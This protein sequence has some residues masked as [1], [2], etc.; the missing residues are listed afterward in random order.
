[1]RNK[2]LTEEKTWIWPLLGAIGIYVVISILVHAISL[3][4][5]LVN[6]TLAGFLILLSLAQMTV[7]TSG[8]G[9]IDLSN[10]YT[11]AL[12]AYISSIVM[13][14]YGIVAGIIVTLAVCIL[15][16]FMNGVINVYLK[17]PAM[18][19]TLAVGYI[20]YSAVLM[21]SGI[22]TGRP[23]SVIMHLTQECRIL[24]IS[25]LLYIV[26]LII[27]GMQV[28][29]YK[30]K[31]GKYLH[32]VGQ[33]RT[34]TKL[35]GI[36]VNKTIILSFIISSV[37]TGIAGVLLGGYFGGATPDMGLSY[38]VLS[39]G[40]CV[41]GGTSAAGGKSSVVGAVCGSIMLTLLVSFLN[42]TR[43]PPSYQDIIEGALL[44]F[45]LVASM[46]RVRISKFK[47]SHN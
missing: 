2:T 17:V 29:L 6:L 7:I 9:A 23:S 18:I 3:K 10:Q 46:P 13:I 30:T 37:L 36:N 15:I 25:P 41:I 31:Y 20:T 39:I 14:N 40:S 47:V 44:M 12:S 33:N 1:M 38:L 22:T 11:V 42:L 34:A 35:A 5:L 24:G 16:G 45:I 27:I 28:L 43:L 8:D 4:F 32:A 19:T 21:I 26:V